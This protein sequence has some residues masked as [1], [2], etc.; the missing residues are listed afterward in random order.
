MPKV[1]KAR[2]FRASTTL[3]R[4]TTTKKAATSADGDTNDHGHFLKNKKAL[5]SSSSLSSPQ[6]D[7]NHAA[8]D[9]MTALD[10][11]VKSKK[12]AAYSATK[13]SKQDETAGATPP[14]STKK[15]SIKKKEEDLTPAAGSDTKRKGVK[16]SAAA[17]ANDG[18]STALSR[19]QRKRQAK[20]EQYL[21][22]EKMVMSSLK[23][24]KAEEQAK[25]IDGLDAI[26]EALLETVAASELGSKSSKKEQQKQQQP[27]LLHSNRG[28]QK[29]VAQEVAQMNLV[30]QHPAYQADPLATL[31]EH[32]RNSIQP[33]D[34]DSKQSTQQQQASGAKKVKRKRHKSK[35]RATRSRNR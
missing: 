13:S 14:A 16:K 31:R 29:L 21:R 17:V 23:L 32:L 7:K 33:D 9:L 11:S 4:K 30:L 1:S 28:R 19:G 27:N 25:R 26:K 34:D 15:D 8:V 20:R 24:K 2:K 6:A 22:K 3:H 5:A 35:Y 10:D 18:Q 12:P